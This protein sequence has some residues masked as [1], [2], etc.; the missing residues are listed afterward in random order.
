VINFEDE[1][2]EQGNKRLDRYG[3]TIVPRTKE[4]LKQERDLLESFSSVVYTKLGILYNNTE[5]N[6]N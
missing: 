1:N 2:G 3:S 5:Q 6:D 4:Q